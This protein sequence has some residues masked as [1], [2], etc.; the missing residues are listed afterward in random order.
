LS[1]EEK[2]AWYDAEVS[3]AGP[4]GT[5]TAYGIDTF[6]RGTNL[7]LPAGARY[8]LHMGFRRASA[9]WVSRVAWADHSHE[10]AWYAFVAK[11]SLR[12]LLLFGFPPPGDPYWTEETLNGMAERYRGLDVSRFRAADQ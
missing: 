4:A 2:P 5:V 9:E 8:T 11:A 12:Q 1:K 6:H 7:T 10:P 3:S